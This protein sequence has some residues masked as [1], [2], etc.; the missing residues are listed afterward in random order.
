MAARLKKTDWIAHG[1]EVLRSAGYAGLKADRM[2]RA[3]GVSRGS[4]YWHFADIEDFHTQLIAHWR[5]EITEAVIADLQ[6]MPEGSD[7]LV[8]LVTRVLSVPQRLERAIRLWAGSS[9]PVAAAVAEVDALR[10]GYVAA[11][12]QGLGFTKDTAFARA[13]F[14]GWAYTGHALSGVDVQDPAARA[15]DCAWMLT[16]PEER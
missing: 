16:R 8:E 1:W 5:Q 12:L 6:A 2:V 14:L 4:F 7:P 13:T 10:V 11:H 9:A 15:T 3:L